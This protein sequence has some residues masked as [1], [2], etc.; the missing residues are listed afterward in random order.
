ML[1][2][3]LAGS[4]KRYK[5]DTNVFATW[6]STTAKACGYK[7]EIS[8]RTPVQ[9]DAPKT[10]SIRLKGKARKE[11]QKAAANGDGP[12]QEVK[13]ADLQVTRYTVKTKDFLDQAKV[14]TKSVRPRIQMPL[15]ILR[16]VQRAIHARKRCADWFRKTGAKDEASIEGHD[17][18]INVLENALAILLPCCPKSAQ[19]SKQE[20]KPKTSALEPESGHNLSNRFGMLNVEDTNDIVLDLAASD[21]SATSAAKKSSKATTPHSWDVYELEIQHGTD[22]A[23]L[24]FCFFEDLHRIQDFIKETWDKQKAGTV[25]LEAAAVTTNIALDIVRRA[26]E[27]IIATAPAMLAKPRSFQAIAMVIFHADALAKGDDVD[28]RLSSSDT[29]KITEFDEFIYLSTARI[30]MKYEQIS[31]FKIEQYPLPV[32]PV[33]MSYISRPELLVLPEVKRWEEEDVRLTQMLMDMSSHDVFQKVFK[34]RKEPVQ[35]E[36]STGLHKLRNGEVSVWIVF[37]ARVCLDIQAILGKKVGKP[38]ETLKT[39]AKAASVVLDMRVEGDELVP[40]GSGE[41]WLAKDADHMMNLHAMLTFWI[42]N[43]PFPY[44]KEKILEDH[45]PDEWVK[46]PEDMKGV[47]KE[48]E[49][50]NNRNVLPQHR[51]TAKKLN[52]RPIEPNPEL[53]YIFTRNPVYCGILAFN[54]AVDMEEAGVALANHHLT[55]FTMS[56]LYNALQQIGLLKGRWPEMDSII[57]LHIK[58]LFAGD[59]PTNPNECHCRFSLQMGLSARKYEQQAS[60]RLIRAS[61]KKKRP[62]LSVTP[63]SAIF[64]RFFDR[65]EPLKDAI[66]WLESLMQESKK[67]NKKGTRR[68]LTP[69][70]FLTQLSDWLPKTIPDIHIDYVSMTR[71]CGMLLKTLRSECLSQLD[72]EYKETN[73]EDTNE[74][75]YLVM[76]LQI[77][78]ETSDFQYFKEQIMRAGAGEDPEL[79]EGPQLELAGE[80]VQKFLDERGLL[81][82]VEALVMGPERPPL[83]VA[84][85]LPTSLSTVVA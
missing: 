81:K 21:I 70:E 56:H 44:L 7:S 37:A 49:E 68:T 10:P 36:L 58:A 64:R 11:A 71:T 79:P 1:P 46:V 84:D 59:L 74:P 47:M 54:V 16:V 80:I 57:K 8:P 32:P 18:F 63:T 19:T 50:M 4:Y 42:I 40:G 39:A 77:L 51:E 67:S 5:E 43:N 35:D 85:P 75:V 12:S 22:L 6:L 48:V 53:T 2:E 26:E 33:R 72:I 34:D 83:V 9:K 15:N 82:K 30:L 29:L 41:R 25:D 73:H 17:H 45:D 52:I 65:K 55:I 28:K 69:L 38:Y 61:T 76:L 14:V 78:A 60:Y 13:L 66:F 31:S 20:H 23:F 3:I 27:D 24:I 62:M